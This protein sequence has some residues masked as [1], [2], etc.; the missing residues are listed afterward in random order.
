MGSFTRSNS[1]GIMS[2]QGANERSVLL[3]VGG[4]LTVPDV[5]SKEELAERLGSGKHVLNL[6]GAEVRISDD[7]R[8]ALYEA[9]GVEP[10]SDDELKA[11]LLLNGVVSNAP[12][13]SHEL[14]KRFLR[15]G[16]REQHFAVVRELARRR[17]EELEKG[18][19]KPMPQRVPS[20]LRSQANGDTAGEPVP[21]VTVHGA[22]EA[23]QVAPDERAEANSSVATP[24][25]GAEQGKEVALSPHDLE[26]LSTYKSTTTASD[27][28]TA[29][30]R[31][32]M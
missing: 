4:E 24:A 10:L 25:A 18:L 23:G 31:S 14:V 2:F 11:R 3:E 32:D 22:E 28:G 20:R 21:A 19:K 15:K 12:P 5:G 26:E 7:I 16:T 13:G 1:S 29:R 27:L 9:L 8:K 17:R 6:S 30:G